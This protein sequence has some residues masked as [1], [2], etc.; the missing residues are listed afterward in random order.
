MRLSTSADNSYRPRPICAIRYPN[1]ALSREN[2]ELQHRRTPGIAF[3]P[4]SKHRQMGDSLN[5]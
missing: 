2:G 4:S 5:G 1:T 3:L